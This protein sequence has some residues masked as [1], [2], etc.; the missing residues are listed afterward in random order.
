MPS[1]T[2]KQ[3]S[4]KNIPWKRIGLWGGV[5]LLIVLSIW[6][7]AKLGE[8]G[9]TPIMSTTPA[10]L[11]PVEST[12][13]VRGNVLSRVTVVEYS[14]FQCPACAAFEPLIV[15]VMAEFG[16]RVRF[17]YRHFPLQQHAHSQAAALAAEAAGRQGKFWE[18]HDKLFASQNSWEG[19]TDE[20]AQKIF[21]RLASEIPLN[22]EQ[23]QKDLSSGNLTAHIERDEK[24]GNA[25]GV[26]ATP[27]FFLNGVRLKPQNFDEFRNAI[28]Q[29]IDNSSLATTP[30]STK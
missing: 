20:G 3:S 18:M 2:Q 23:F 6:G 12:D 1:T 27:S 10:N 22:V 29:T 25:A 7:I 16:T 4:A 5:L 8:R 14:D 30:S 11:A 17:V 15:R 19:E 28:K 24:S 21:I 13:W 9:Q 26:D